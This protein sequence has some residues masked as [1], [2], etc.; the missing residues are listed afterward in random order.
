MFMAWFENYARLLH[1][2][3]PYLIMVLTLTISNVKTTTI[4]NGTKIPKHTRDLACRLTFGEEVKEKKR[5]SL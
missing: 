4:R 2:M 5:P 3:G 1:L